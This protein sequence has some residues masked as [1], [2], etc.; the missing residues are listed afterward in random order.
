MKAAFLVGAGRFEIREIP[1]LFAPEDGLVLEVRACGVCGS[2]LRRW[3]EGPL[4]GSGDVIAGHEIAG[5]VL[6]VGSRVKDY[7]P[8]DRLAVA[9][10]VHCGRCYFCKRGL[11]NLCDDI[12]LIGIS[13]GYPGGFAEQMVLTAEILNLGIVHL[14]PAELSFREAAFAE[15]LSSVLAAHAKANT[16]LEDTVLIMGAGPIGCLHIVVAK[17]RG[18]RVILSEPHET[19][20]EWAKMFGPDQVLNPLQEDVVSQVRRFTGNLGADI[21]ICANPI[22]ETQKQAVEAVR[23]GGRVI[24]FGGLPKANPMT[25]LNAN[26]IHYGEINVV[27]AFSYHPSYHQ[28]ALEVI[29]RGLVPVEQLIT[30]TFPL[31]QINE[32]FSMASQ[33]EALKVMIENQLPREEN[34]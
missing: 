21:V 7:K 9:P 4:P 20:R 16:N 10:D 6:T 1:Q 15:P 29:R 25:T 23:K 26:L 2:D 27:G 3:R 31:E 28:Q 17:A 13:P 12:H 33:G 24:L 14:I 32:A 11:Y 34:L 22:A 30:H 18:A 19:R 8:G 5:I